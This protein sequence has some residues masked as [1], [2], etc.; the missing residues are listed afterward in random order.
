[1]GIGLIPDRAFAVLSEGMKL[2]SVPLLDP[3]AERRLKILVRDPKGLSATS[4]LM[5]DHLKAAEQRQV[6]PQS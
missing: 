6:A 5:F 1:M 4:R 2:H 3:W